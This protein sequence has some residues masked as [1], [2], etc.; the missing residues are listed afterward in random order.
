[1]EPWYCFVTLSRPCNNC[2]NELS[3]LYK[4]IDDSYDAF[5]LRTRKDT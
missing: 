3:L 2:E 5:V 1:M 4:G